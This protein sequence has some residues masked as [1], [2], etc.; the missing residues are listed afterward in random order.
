MRFEA[1]V[2]LL[3]VD[4]E[5]CREKV[6]R[7]TS[8]AYIKRQV[9]EE[10]ATELQEL[11]I[12]GIGFEPAIKRVYPYGNLASQVLGVVN[13]D[14]EGLSGLEKEYNEVAYGR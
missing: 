2:R 13:I 3:G 11:E 6:E 5:E 14:N 10:V 1:L 4:E 7:D 12:A 9:D 8:F